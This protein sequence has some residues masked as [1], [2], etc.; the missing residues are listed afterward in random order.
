LVED[1]ASLRKVLCH[2]LER[3]G[4]RV[5]S[6]GSGEEALHVAASHRGVI[7]LLLTDVITPRM[8]GP[9]LAKRLARLP[10]GISVL[11][12]IRLRR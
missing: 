11:V 4:Y 7:H 2:N 9:E 8:D 3:S 1:L 5:I 6:A 12:H 10:P